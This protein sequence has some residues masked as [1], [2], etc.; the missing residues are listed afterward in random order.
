MSDNGSDS[1]PNSSTQATLNNASGVLALDNCF[2]E[3]ETKNSHLFMNKN[4]IGFLE[5][6]P[7]WEFQRDK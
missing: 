2:I 6:D 1:T 3:S 5:E 7:E 4:D